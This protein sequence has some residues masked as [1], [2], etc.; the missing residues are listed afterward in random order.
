MNR[1]PDAIDQLQRVVDMRPEE[2]LGARARAER[3]LRLA[4]ARSTRR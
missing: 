1:V 3:D 4:I 2:P